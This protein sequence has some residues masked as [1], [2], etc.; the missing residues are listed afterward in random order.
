M[1]TQN[2]WVLASALCDLHQ[3][4]VPPSLT[5]SESIIPWKLWWSL[6]GSAKLHHPP[7]LKDSY[8]QG[9]RGVR[10]NDSTPEKSSTHQTQPGLR[11]PESALETLA[12][13]SPL[14][15]VEVGRRPWAPAPPSSPGYQQASSKHTADP[16][17]CWISQSHIEE[18]HSWATSIQWEHGQHPSP[19]LSC[20]LARSPLSLQA[21][22]REAR[23][24]CLPRQMIHRLDFLTLRLSR[25]VVLP[26]RQPPRTQP[27]SAPSA[28]LRWA[29][30]ENRA[31]QQTSGHRQHKALS[32]ELRK[33][34]ENRVAADLGST[35]SW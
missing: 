13:C 33:G 2:A 3:A 8:T 11:V 28:E 6:L 12:S 14:P 18:P 19:S 10:P 15:A 25:G 35:P 30:T 21:R 24:T 5:F 23:Q 22:P 34:G 16:L 29:S 31:S 20:A 4:P 27:R 32:E 1:K 9:R 7:E 26:C 17:W